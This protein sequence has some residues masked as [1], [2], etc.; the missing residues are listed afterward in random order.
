MCKVT[1][2]SQLGQADI[3]LHP[4]ADFIGCLIAAA[5]ATMPQFLDALMKCLAAPGGSDDYKPGHRTR[6]N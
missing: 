6:C 2:T 5:I 3:D 1:V 4:Q